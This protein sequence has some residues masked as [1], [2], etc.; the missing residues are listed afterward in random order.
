MPLSA[1]LRLSP[2]A[3][4][5]V[6]MRL[7]IYLGVQ[8][9]YFIGVIGTLTFAM[10]GGVGENVLGIAALNGCMILGSL[11]GGPVLDRIGP[12]RYFRTVVAALVAASLF[13][14]VLA[15][16]VSGVIVGAMLLG[17]S[18]GMGEH[19]AKAFPAYLTDDA[20]ELKNINSVVFTVSNAA[21]IVGPLIGGVV[22]ASLGTKAVFLFLAGCSLLALIPAAGFHALRRP[23]E[24]AGERDEAGGLTRGW[25]TVFGLP[26]L[27]LLFWSCFFSFFG[28]GAFDPVES[29]YYRD[30]L[31]VGVEWMGWLSSASG[32]G[33]MAGSFLV[34][35]IPARHVNMRTLL[36]TLAAEG[37][38]CLIYVGT[39]SVVVA[40]AGQILLGVAFG[41]LMPLL[42]TLVQLHSP[43]SAIGS[44]NA[45]MSFGNNV[46][47]LAP[48][49]CAEALSRAFGVQGTLIAASL[50][51]LLMP[52]LI[53]LTQ[54]R[55]ISSLVAEE[56]ELSE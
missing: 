20:E 41:A 9:G 47:G 49:L 45:V 1:A 51:V 22:A 10:D 43:L 8:C 32:V 21:V 54:H 38:C 46:A 27:S 16:S 34:L 31:N 7:L 6:A 33:G 26:A 2:M 3:R 42:S 53:A 36:L 56:R 18:W 5:L 29:L 30:V 44:V 40:C 50:L 11:V 28:Y 12:A 24:D 14:Q 55:R 35:R 37:A 39:S 19:V 23:Q 17:F 15:A 48:L 52:I 13:F 4:R 25:S